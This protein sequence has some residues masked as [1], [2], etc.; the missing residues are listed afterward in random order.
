VSLVGRFSNSDVLLDRKTCTLCVELSQS[1]IVNLK[2][3]LSLR[4]NKGVV[5]SRH[6]LC[7]LQKKKI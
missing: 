7:V 3:L 1:S 5:R 2:H 4:S 6:S